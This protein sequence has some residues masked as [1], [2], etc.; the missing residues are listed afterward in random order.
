VVPNLQRLGLI[1]ER[2]ERDWRRVG[3]M[4]DQRGGMPTFGL[5]LVS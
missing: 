2:T 5:P 3:L 1:T 4:V